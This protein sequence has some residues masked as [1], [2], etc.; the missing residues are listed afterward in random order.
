MPNKISSR[1]RRKL[2]CRNARY[3]QVHTGA[4]HAG[5]MTVPCHTHMPMPDHGVKKKK[6]FLN[7]FRPDDT[8]D[9]MQQGLMTLHHIISLQH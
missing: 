9:H 8:S 1:M 2:A 4:L 5:F 3:R 7:M 6:I